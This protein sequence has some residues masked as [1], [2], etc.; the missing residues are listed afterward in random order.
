MGPWTHKN[1]KIEEISCSEVQ[2][3]LF[4]GLEASPLVLKS[5]A[6]T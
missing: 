2:D 5:L 4:G 3:V 1:I 6:K